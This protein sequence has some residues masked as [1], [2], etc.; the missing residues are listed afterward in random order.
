ML[1]VEGAVINITNVLLIGP[2]GHL[3][4]ANFF[5]APAKR[6]LPKKATVAADAKPAAPKMPPHAKPPTDQ[7]RNFQQCN[8]QILCTNTLQRK[9]LKPSR[10]SC[11]QT[12]CGDMYKYAYNT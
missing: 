9:G 6:P 8:A 2:G 7:V 12:V 4:A 1:G 5:A 10:N 3:D 11:S